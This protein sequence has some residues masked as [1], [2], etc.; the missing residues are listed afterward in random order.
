VYHAAPLADFQA[1]ETLIPPGCAIDF[2]D[3]SSG[4]PTSWHWEFDG[5][6]PVTSSERNPS[7]IV[8]E[9]TGTYQVKLIVINEAGTDSVIFSDYIIVTDTILPLVDFIADQTVVC[10]NGIAHFTDLTQY[11]PN[12]WEWLFSP[13]TIDFKEGTSE[14]SQHPVVEFR[15]PGLYEVTLNVSNNNGQG[16][17]TRTGYIQAGG[18][19]LPFEENFESG[20]LEDR[21]WTVVNAD[22]GYTW[23]NYLIEETGN[24]AAR[25]KFYGYFKMSERDKLISPYLNFSELT[26]IYLTFDHAYAQ[27]FNQKDSLI[28]YVSSGCEEN[29]IRIWANGPDGNGI[30]ETSPATPYEFIPLVNDDWCS[31]GWGADCFTLDLSQWA[32]DINVKIM[33]ESYNNLGNNLYLDNIIVSNTTGNANILPPLGTFTLYPNPGSG[34]FTLYSAG[35]TGQMEMEVYNA[36]GQSVIKNAFNNNDAAYQQTIDLSGFPKGVYMVRLISDEKVQLKKI[37]LE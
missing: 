4:I 31:L 32:G 28:I 10:T 24:H 8:Y 18:S 11:C 9:S 1:N 16:T 30:F 5:A 14:N 26:N 33:F 27:R 15:Q 20:S 34:L 19:F 7:G 2:T 17:L 25:M 37:I 35:L 29:W 13:A 36:Q 22:L 23:T 3:L 21:N 6:S 12:T